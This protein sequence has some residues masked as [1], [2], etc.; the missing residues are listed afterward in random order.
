MTPG[1]P[2]TWSRQVSRRANAV[3]W[4][5]DETTRNRHGVPPASAEK[6]AC[7]TVPD[8]RQKMR[9][10]VEFM[11]QEWNAALVDLSRC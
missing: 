10:P 1:Y 5:T 7:L 8:G 4:F 3:R 2:T 11:D 6:Q 9:E